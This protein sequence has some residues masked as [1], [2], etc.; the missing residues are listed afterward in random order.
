MA[1]KWLRKAPLTK[2]AV[3]FGH[4]WAQ[5]SLGKITSG[6]VLGSSP[7]QSQVMAYWP[8][9]SIKW[10]KHAGVFAAGMHDLQ[11]K[12]S[13]ELQSEHIAIEKYNGIYIDNGCFKVFFS[14]HGELQ[15][16]IEWLKV[17]NDVKLSHL[18]VGAVFKDQD[19]T[20][21]K[22]NISLEENGP[23]KSVVKVEGD[24]TYLGDVY[25]KIIIRFR[26][27]KE[28]STFDIVH[29]MILVKTENYDG[30]YIKAKAPLRGEAWNRF[31][32]I[33]GAQVYTEPAQLFLSRRYSENNLA[34]KEQVK[35]KVTAESELDPEMMIHTKE[36]AIW[37]NFRLIQESP[38]SFSFSKMTQKGYAS[39]EAGRGDRSKGAIYVG[40]VDGG[41]AMGMA[42]FWEKAP[43][44]LE[45]SDLTGNE[46]TITAWLWS[47]SGPPMDFSHYSNRDHMLSA[48]EGME[49][50]RSTAV[51]I[52]NTNLLQISL[53][54]QPATQE[55][56]GLFADNLQNNPQIVC[57]PEDY[58]QTKVFGVWP[59]MDH[60]TP[61]KH[62]LEDQMASLKQFYL[63]EV[64]QRDWYGFWHFGDVMHT[65]DADRHVWRYD[66]GGYAW[67]NTE[68]V[69]NMWLWLDFLRTGDP[70]VFDFAAAMTRHTS[71]V[72]QY[73]LG[74]YQGLGSRHNV[75]HWGCQCKEARISMAGLHR[76]YYYLTGDERIG[77]IIA[78]VKDNDTVIFNQLAPLREFYP[79]I[80]EEQYPI[81]VGPDWSSL[82]SNW[83]TEW[84]RSGNQ[85]Y[86]E[87]IKTGINDIKATPNR[88]LSGPTYLFDTNTK[89]LTYYGTGNIGG[90]HMIIAFGA[91]QVWLELEQL[92]D[93]QDWSTMLAEFGRFYALSDEK[94]QEESQKKL[95]D[96]HFSWPFFATGLMAYA[97]QFYQ[98]KELAKKAWDILLNESI[99][100]P[101]SSTMK[102]AV[103]WKPITELPWIS[104][105]TVSQWCLNVL[106][107]LV[108]IG[109]DI[110]SEIINIK[111]EI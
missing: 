20:F 104:T 66:I 94:K 3:T 90:Y 101:V 78:S 35:G 25:Q 79:E 68:L 61:M 13:E 87:Y 4:P 59:L 22:T 77:D 73:H 81:R 23:I 54:S 7:L 49:E 29:T 92:L 99:P 36:Q 48:Y 91:P 24:I 10:T 41:V 56:F 107:C 62:F 30:I 97:A 19:L 85:L 39:I 70:A 43:R 6:Y 86:L 102:E 12:E 109:D 57:Y 44:E 38:S 53:F 83:F 69:P 16:I 18:T 88:L 74:E 93:D 27:F 67:Q 17:N 50:L 106:L 103:I 76:Y 60:S 40:G 5:G 55:Q 95:N 32:S 45:V 65:Y 75:L 84:E 34:Y 63:N 58:H 108:Y 8:D 80:I 14:K 26:F 42:H 2:Q 71:E 47:R 51:G 52:A 100:L 33:A 98:D 9:G 21:V 15:H 89:H 72:D 28:L 37:N 82:T 105:N 110:S 11:L 1:L 31:V 96:Q 64:E 46:T 111:E